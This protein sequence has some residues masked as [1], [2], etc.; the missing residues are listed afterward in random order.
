MS[1]ITEKKIDAHTKVS[2]S[3]LDTGYALGKAE[4]KKKVGE[5]VDDKIAQIK[6][7]RDEQRLKP[8]WRTSQTRKKEMRHIKLLEDLKQKI[9]GMK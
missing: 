2:I 7:R 8:N 6:K 5:I 4:T 9:E 3:A 1:E